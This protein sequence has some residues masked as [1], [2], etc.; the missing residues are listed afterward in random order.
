MNNLQT[1]DRFGD[2][3]NNEPLTYADILLIAVRYPGKP[4][5]KT[6]AMGESISELLERRTLIMALKKC[7]LDGEIKLDHEDWAKLNEL[8][9]AKENWPIFDGITDVALA[10]REEM[11]KVDSEEGAVDEPTD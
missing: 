1:Q 4:D 11:G 9:Y 10:L 3:N 7:E 2:I 8:F 6:G 5:P